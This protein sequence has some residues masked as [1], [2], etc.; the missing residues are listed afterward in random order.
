MAAAPPGSPVAAV[1]GYWIAWRVTGIGLDRRLLGGGPT[2]GRAGAGN[3]S[4]LAQPASVDEVRELSR[5]LAEA[6]AAIRD[7][8]ERQRLAEQALRPVDRAKD[9]FLAMLGHELRNPLGAIVSASTSSTWRRAD[10]VIGHASRDA[11][12][13]RS[14]T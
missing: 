12:S 7:R 4:A 1:L 13:A 8:E 10:P 14:S 2:A 5:A 11:S 9:E 6:A 3:R